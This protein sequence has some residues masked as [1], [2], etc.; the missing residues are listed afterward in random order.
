MIM[1]G[2]D[3]RQSLSS[4]PDHPGCSHLVNVNEVRPLP[5]H[6]GF[7]CTK[8]FVRRRPEDRG[9]FMYRYVRKER[10]IAVSTY[11]HGHAPHL[12]ER[13]DRASHNGL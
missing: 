3:R 9:D 12:G 5:L 10:R 7:E 6:D 8:G 13:R 4:E 2:D 1:N 11:Y